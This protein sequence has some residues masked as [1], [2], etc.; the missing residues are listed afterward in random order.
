MYT[1]LHLEV[2]LM[3]ASKMIF[4]LMNYE[5]S[6]LV[7]TT[8]FALLSAKHTLAQLIK[9]YMLYNLPILFLCLSYSHVTCVELW[10]FSSLMHFAGNLLILLKTS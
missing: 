1:A 7:F 9:Y 5:V 3:L 2:W 8:F 4:S 10:L 6:I